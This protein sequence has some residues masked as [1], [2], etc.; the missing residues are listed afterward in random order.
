MH[1]KQKITALPPFLKG[2]GGNFAV[3]F[4]PDH[5]NSWFFFQIML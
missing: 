4:P 3:L 1:R 2:I 5:P